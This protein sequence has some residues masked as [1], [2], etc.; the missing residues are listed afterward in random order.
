MA[1]AVNAALCAECHRPHAMSGRDWLRGFEG[2]L[3]CGVIHGW[4]AEQ[5]TVYTIKRLKVQVQHLESALENHDTTG[6]QN[7]AVD[8]VVKSLNR[9][10]DAR[11]QVSE[12]ENRA[13][14]MLTER[15]L[16]LQR[17]YLSR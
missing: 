2:G 16:E 14:Q 5:C 12:F 8:Q 15:I 11:L 3:D 9:I 10:L 1:D 7:H 17:G 13:L 4:G 6:A